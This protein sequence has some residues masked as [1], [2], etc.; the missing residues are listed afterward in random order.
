MTTEIGERSVEEFL[1]LAT[2]ASRGENNVFFQRSL[3]L[4]GS[5]DRAIDSTR[6]FSRLVDEFARRFGADRRICLYESPGR[7][8][9]MGM[10]VDHRGGIVNP[11]ATQERIRAV[12]SRRDDD[13]VRA[14]S[15]LRDLGEGQFRISDRLPRTPLGSLGDWLNWTEQQAVA[16]RGGTDFIN[17]FA[18][19]PLY[20]ACFCYP[21]GRKFAGADFLLDSDLPPSAGLSSSSAV[22][23]LAT[24]FFLRCNPEGVEDLS[25]DRLL[26]VYGYGEWY[27]GTRGGTGDQAAIKLCRRGAIQPLITTP[28]SK[29]AST[30]RSFPTRPAR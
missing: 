13:L 1:S 10:H 2:S 9:L 21:W 4:H 18:C 7:V 28:G 29:P 25:I 5:R 14:V 30:R 6:R 3:V 16:T 20:A 17:Y 23:V 27:I 24:D 8:N 15:L 12:C 26:E 19:G 22:V 11:V